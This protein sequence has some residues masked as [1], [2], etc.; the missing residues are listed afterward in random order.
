MV[1]GSGIPTLNFPV[2]LDTKDIYPLIREMWLSEQIPEKRMIE[3][4]NENPDLKEWWYGQER[5]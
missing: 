2:H 5:H 1:I 3:I 4:L